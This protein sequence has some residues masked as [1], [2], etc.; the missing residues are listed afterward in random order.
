VPTWRH[1]EP[2]QHVVREVGE[3]VPRTGHV[4]VADV[5]LEQLPRD[6]GTED[7][8]QDRHVGD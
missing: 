1:R 5:Q 4:E 2:S 6:A 3:R 7:E 8:R